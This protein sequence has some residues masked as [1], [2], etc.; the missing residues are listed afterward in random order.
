MNKTHNRYIFDIILFVVA[1]TLYSPSLWCGF[2]GDDVIYFIGNRLIKSFDLV[3]ILRSGAIGDDYLPLRDISFAMDYRIWGEN[4]F[5][6]HLTNIILYGLTV[7]AVK[8][9]FVR[10]NTFLDGTGRDVSEI[11]AFLVTLLFALHP[12]HRDIVFAIHNRGAL[13]T[14]LFSILSCSFFLKFIQNCNGK[15]R[16]YTIAL[17]CFICALMSREYSIILP[18]VFVLMIFFDE[19]SNRIKYLTFTI[20]FF[21][22]SALFFYIY[23]Q[24]AVAAKYITSSS[25]PLLSESITKM[26]VAIKIV[27]FYMV[28]MVTFLGKF[29]QA[30]TVIYTMISTLA[31]AGML[32]AAILVRRRYPQLLFG[33]LFYLICLV[34]VLN[35]YKTDPI[36]AARY[37]YLPCLGL[38]F[39]FMAVPFTGRKRLIPIFCIAFTAGW[40]LLTN[41]QARFYKNNIIY[42]ENIVPYVKSS[43]TLTQ[44]GYA[45]FSDKQYKKA[46]DALR[47]VQPVPKEPRFLETLGNS[48]FE[49]GN[50]QC[51]IQ[52]YENLMV[53]DPSGVVAPASLAKTYQMLGNQTNVDKYNE[54]SIRNFSLVNKNDLKTQGN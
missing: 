44:L 2:V 39:A 34:P 48:C 46:F 49:I 41:Y 40:F 13:L 25:E 28:R 42:W 6:F 23:K 15:S 26:A 32:V 36:V 16:S 22:T 3:T 18:L 29:S 12:I 30:D 45:Y 33:L 19:H 9:I 51:A 4:P 7:V 5:G 8:H 14:V 10:L 37:S 43:E 21:I 17:I 24:Y 35:F 47:E 20:P 1:A 11:P 54:L 52:A 27:L 53:L 38:F 31:V 50:F